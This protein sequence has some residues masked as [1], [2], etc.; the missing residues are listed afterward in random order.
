MQMPYQGGMGW[1]PPP[2]MA[3]P[4]PPV[5]GRFKHHAIVLAAVLVAVWFIGSNYGLRG[6]AVAGLGWMLWSLFAARR[7]TG[8]GPRALV[9][10]GVVAAL[11]L[12]TI[13]P[14]P[15]VRMPDRSPDVETSLEGVRQDVGDF[16]QRVITAGDSQPERPARRGGGR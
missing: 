5:R 10:Y 9:E 4:R 11:L 14:I 15:T 13:V 7:A 16:W 1:G 6:L 12:L 2:M 8:Q 3:P